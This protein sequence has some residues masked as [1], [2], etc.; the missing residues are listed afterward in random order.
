M[1]PLSALVMS[2]AT[3]PSSIPSPPPDDMFLSASEHE[4][5]HLMLGL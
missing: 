3:V 4:A 5:N 2:V 1:L